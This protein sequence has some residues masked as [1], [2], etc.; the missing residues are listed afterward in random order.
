MNTEES[1]SSQELEEK[2]PSLRAERC[3]IASLLSSVIKF[4]LFSK[5]KPLAFQ[6]R[7]DHLASKIDE[8]STTEAAASEEIPEEIPENRPLNRKEKRKL[9]RMQEIDQEVKKKAQEPVEIAEIPTNLK[10]TFWYLK[11]RILSQKI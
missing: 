8:L 3:G 11:I 7:S 10:N 4:H 6:L 2:K 5:E 9:Q 1:S